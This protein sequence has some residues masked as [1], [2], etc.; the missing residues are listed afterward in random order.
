M[1]RCIQNQPFITVRVLGYCMSSKEMGQIEA[2][3][4]YIKSVSQALTRN[5]LSVREFLILRAMDIDLK[6][7]T[8]REF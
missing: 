1:L 7:A 5:S 2:N 6:K 8:S 3:F 4:F